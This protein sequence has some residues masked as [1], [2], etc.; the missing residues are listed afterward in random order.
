MSSFFGYSEEVQALLGDLFPP[1]VDPCDWY[2]P[3]LLLFLWFR[4]C[5][6]VN[7]YAHTHAQRGTHTHSDRQTD[8]QALRVAHTQT[9]TH[10]HTQI[11]TQTNTSPLL[12]TLIA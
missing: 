4:C 11:L 2:P 12:F 9:Q 10:T 7:S 6:C 5:F 3:V 1:V 8:R